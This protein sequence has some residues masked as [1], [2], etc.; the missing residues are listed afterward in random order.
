MSGLLTQRDT[1][2]LSLG[3]GL[4]LLGF[5][6]KGLIGGAVGLVGT[7]AVGKLLEARAKGMI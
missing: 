6:L 5:V 3:L 4:G 1:R 2:V 7:V